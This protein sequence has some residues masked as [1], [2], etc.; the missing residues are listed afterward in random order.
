VSVVVKETVAPSCGTYAGVVVGV[1]VTVLYVTV[2]VVPKDAAPVTDNDSMLVEYSVA[3]PLVVRFKFPPTLNAPLMELSCSTMF[4]VSKRISAELDGG[5]ATPAPAAV[6]L[7]A[8]V[9]A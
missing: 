1:S 5:I 3:V 7:P 8:V 9:L 6:V 4:V 2:C